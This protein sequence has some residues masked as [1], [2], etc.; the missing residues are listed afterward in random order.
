MANYKTYVQRC[1]IDSIKFESNFTYILYGSN[2]SVGAAIPFDVQP[3]QTSILH[4]NSTKIMKL[5]VL[6]DWSDLHEKVT[7][8]KS[9]NQSLDKLRLE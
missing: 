4:P 3:I 8:Y 7:E 6:A 9:V 1:S 2:S 5:I